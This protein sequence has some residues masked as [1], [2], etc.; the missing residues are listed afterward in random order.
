MRRHHRHHHCSTIAVRA[1][2]AA[3]VVSSGACESKP[4]TGPSD[5]P[6]VD[7]APTVTEVSLSTGSTVGGAP[8]VISGTGFMTGAMVTF[9]GISAHL[10]TL[11]TAHLFEGR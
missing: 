8:V 6:V 9:G 3:V 1:W 4:I 10:G 11:K 7:G 2:L 5:V